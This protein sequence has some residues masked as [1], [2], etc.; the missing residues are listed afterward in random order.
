MANYVDFISDED[1]EEV[2][3]TLI[4]KYEKTKDEMSYKKFTANQIDPIKFIFDKNILDQSDE[5]KIKA[6]ITRKIDRTIANAIGDFHENLL[7]KIKGY[8]KYPVGHGY[9]IK[10][11]NDSLYADIKNK[12]NTVKGSDLKNLYKDLESYIQK[13]KNPDAKAYWVQIISGGKSFNE[14]WNIPIEKLDNPKVF[15]ISGDKFYELL[16]GKKN[17]FFEVC[18]ALPSVINKVKNE[19]QYKIMAENTQVIKKLKLTSEIENIDITTQIFNET[20]KNYN[21]FPIKP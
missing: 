7:G 6:E 2:V 4:E 11:D 18:V 20:F 14:K 13:S 5:E 21:G 3:R 9:D 15:K 8:K 12:H 19:N 16:T 17:A 1:F 10:A